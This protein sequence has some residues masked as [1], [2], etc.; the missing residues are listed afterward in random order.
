MPEIV[1][2]AQI[3]VECQSQELMLSMKSECTHLDKQW[4]QLSQRQDKWGKMLE[5][6]IAAWE[7][8]LAVQDGL[9]DLE[10]WNSKCYTPAD[11]QAMLVSPMLGR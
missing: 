9:R 8:G 10:Q 5:C 11:K 1:K 7:K 4:A 3:S 6:C 2:Y